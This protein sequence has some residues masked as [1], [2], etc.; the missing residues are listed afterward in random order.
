MVHF[1]KRLKVLIGPASG[2][3]IHPLGRSRF[4]FCPDVRV[5][6]GQTLYSGRVTRI[7]GLERKGNSSMGE[8]G[9]DP[10]AFVL[11][12]PGQVEIRFGIVRLSRHETALHFR[13]HRVTSRT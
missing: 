13:S 12:F 1:V 9:V 3:T 5:Q 2:T 7:H 11:G 4:Y 10:H 8:S 6:S